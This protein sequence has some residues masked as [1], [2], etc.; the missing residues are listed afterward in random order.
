MPKSVC[1]FL[2][3]VAILSAA[4]G[5][6]ARAQPTSDDAVLQAARSLAQQYDAHYAAREAG[7]MAELYAPDGVLVSPAGT[8]V[9]GREALRAYY[10]ARFASGA[11]DHLTTFDEAHGQ[12][13]GGYAIGQFAVTVRAPDGQTKRE[14]GNIAAVYRL[15]PDGWRIRLLVPST[16]P[17]R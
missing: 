16:L 6:A 2:G 17:E 1:L 13:E 14:R 7:A 5:P 10:Q 11:R 8:V 9:R 12:G 3:A 4:A 15:G